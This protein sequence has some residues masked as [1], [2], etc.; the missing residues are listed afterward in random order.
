[1]PGHP[2]YY[3]LHD[4]QIIEDRHERAKE[5]DGGQHLEGKET[6]EAAILARADG[7][8]PKNELRPLGRKIED[9]HEEGADP[10]EEGLWPRERREELAH[11]LTLQDENG[12]G[13][14]EKEARADHSPIDL[15]AMSG[16]RIRN[17]DDD[18]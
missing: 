1:E 3:A 15:A 9:Q 16:K 18:A 12:E 5:D 7:Q 4:P 14:L 11:R 8:I 6:P 10:R 13:D 2:D 17:P